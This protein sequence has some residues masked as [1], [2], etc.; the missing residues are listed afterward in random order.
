MNLF[1][2]MAASMASIIVSGRYACPDT[3]GAARAARRARGSLKMF[4]RV[5]RGVRR[6]PGV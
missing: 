6:R 5:E 1:R 2:N 3:P 4:E